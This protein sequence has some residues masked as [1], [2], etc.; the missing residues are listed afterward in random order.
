M[1]WRT[2]ALKLSPDRAQNSGITVY[3][4]TISLWKHT[5]MVIIKQHTEKHLNRIAVIEQF[6]NSFK[7]KTLSVTAST[8]YSLTW[9][10]GH[11]QMVVFFKQTN[12]WQ[13]RCWWLQSY[14]WILV[15]FGNFSFCKLVWTSG[16]N[17]C[18]PARFPKP[19]FSYDYKIFDIIKTVFKL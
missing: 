18:L 2:P 7:N 17:K 3:Q 9:D 10:K 13:M 8:I 6:W 5:A 12:H 11:C 14:N 4:C 16:M 1:L 15:K 19:I